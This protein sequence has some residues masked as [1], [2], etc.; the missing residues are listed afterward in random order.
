MDNI[1]DFATKYNFA[2]RSSFE[3][4]CA[5]MIPRV[6][7]E[8]KKEELRFCILSLR[9]CDFFRIS[10]ASGV[11]DGGERERG[12]DEALDVDAAQSHDSAV[13]RVLPFAVPQAETSGHLHRIHAR[14]A[15]ENQTAQ[16]THHRSQF[17]RNEQYVDRV[18]HSIVTRREHSKLSEDDRGRWSSSSTAFPPSCKPSKYV[19]PS[20]PFFIPT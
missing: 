15:P 17:S 12:G 19:S 7:G 9:I 3:S 18:A 14:P 10:A 16:R 13:L 8:S 2:F 4:S 20:F 5:G 1:F 11:G 6:L